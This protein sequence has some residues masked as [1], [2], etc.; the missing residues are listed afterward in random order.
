M[1][2][3][4]K[5]VDVLLEKDIRLMFIEDQILD[6]DDKTKDF[7]GSFEFVDYDY[8]KEGRQC[9]ETA[10]VYF[11]NHNVFIKEVASGPCHYKDVMIDGGVDELEYFTVEPTTTIS[12]KNEK[13]IK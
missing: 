6:A 9:I 5:I 8:E 10:V 4:K 12:Y 13:I 11:E 2:P 1:S 3:E 7:L